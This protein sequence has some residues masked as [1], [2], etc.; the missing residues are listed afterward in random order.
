MSDITGSR[1]IAARFGGDEFVLVLPNCDAHE[2][3]ATL[4]RLRSVSG[5]GWTAGVVTWEADTDILGAIFSKFCI[6]K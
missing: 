1:G 3:E 4:E 2:A 5:S 6:G